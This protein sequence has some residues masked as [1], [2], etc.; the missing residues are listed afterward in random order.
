MRVLYLRAAERDDPAEEGADGARYAELTA[1]VADGGSHRR[2]QA[3]V[4]GARLRLHRLDEAVRHGAGGGG[5]GERLHAE[6]HAQGRRR[7][8]RR[9]ASSICL[10]S[11]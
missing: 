4:G 11:E 10:H 9:G 1:V 3:A 8:L 6:S 2:Q 7:R 5:P